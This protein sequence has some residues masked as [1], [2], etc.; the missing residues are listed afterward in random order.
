MILT[1]LYYIILLITSTRHDYKIALKSSIIVMIL[2]MGLRYNYMPDYKN[3]LAYF[4]WVANG[5]IYAEGSDHMEYGWY[6]LNKFLAPL[7]FFGFI[8]LG[9]IIMGWGIYVLLERECDSRYL[10]F[11]ILGIVTTGGTPVLMS[12]FR[13]YIVAAIFLNGFNYFLYGK[14]NTYRDLFKLNILYY[15]ILIFLC[16][17]LHTSASF[18][19]II[20]FLFLVPTNKK[21]AIGIGA[22]LFVAI[23]GGQAFVPSLVKGFYEQHDRYLDILEHE[24][25][26]ENMTA[27]SFL[28][29]SIQIILCS[30][31]FAQNRLNKNSSSIILTAF[32]SIFFAI[33]IFFISQLYRLSMYLIPLYFL[34]IKVIC[35]NW[36]NKNISISYIKCFYGIWI[37]WNALKVFTVRPGSVEEY[38]TIFS[39]IF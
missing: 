17:Q 22:F 35:D 16:S 19:Y 12:A 23:L 10:P 9:A 25:E 7:S 26:M 21:I 2:Y 4:D 20:P 3:Y 32:L 33:S 27:A 39:L 29:Y 15:F 8:F 38:K 18:L 6:V 31:I 1:V 30:C 14:I 11:V 37:F 24:I 36:N 34:S 5:Y 28:S 13:Q